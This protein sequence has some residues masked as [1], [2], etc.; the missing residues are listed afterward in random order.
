MECLGSVLVWTVSPSCFA[1]YRLSARKSRK[2][3]PIVFSTCLG[4]VRCCSFVQRERVPSI[5]NPIS[6]TVIVHGHESRRAMDKMSKL[7]RSRLDTTV[8]LHTMVGI[9]AVG[10][11]RSFVEDSMSWNGAALLTNT[12]CGSVARNMLLACTMCPDRV[13][14]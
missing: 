5:C 12:E 1:V 13:L 3:T 6:V 4:A 8:C 2:P 11:K 14:G 7:N 9:L 10:L